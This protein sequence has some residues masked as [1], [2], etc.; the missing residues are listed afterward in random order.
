MFG[1]ANVGGSVGAALGI[2]NE[3][4]GYEDARWNMEQLQ[5]EAGVASKMAD[6]FQ[7]YRSGMASTLND[8]VTGKK[9]I[10]TDPGY[11]FAFQEG[12]RGVERAAA[13]RGMNNSGNVLAA[14]QQR[15]QDVASQQYGS[16]IDRLTNLAGGGSQNAVAGAQIYGNM[17][18]TG[19]TGAADAEIGMG[20]SQSKQT[21][22]W[23]EAVHNAAVLA[24]SI[25]SSYGMDNQQSKS[26]MP[27]SGSGSTGN[28]Y[29]GGSDTGGGAGMFNIGQFFA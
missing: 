9:S 1:G 27:D 8:Y 25:F 2:K 21:A 12:Q 23:G 26:Y 18:T 6:P 19:L 16:I 13:A 20:M 4:K 14:L 24:G 7:Q 11:Q 3:T 5:R 29:A 15:G 22:A 10:Q 28:Q 17:M